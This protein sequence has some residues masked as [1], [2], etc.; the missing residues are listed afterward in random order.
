M[1][2]VNITYYYPKDILLIKYLFYIKSNPLQETRNNA[3][4]R[5]YEILERP[6]TQCLPIS[7]HCARVVI[8]LF[9]YS[10]KYHFERELNILLGKL[11][12]EEKF[13]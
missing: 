3:W 11:F 9:N 5:N 2:N 8:A 7:C 13:A 4:H 10:M 12:E 6:N 1:M